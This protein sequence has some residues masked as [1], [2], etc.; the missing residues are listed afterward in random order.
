MINPWQTLS[1][2]IAYDNPWIQVTHREVINPSGG[3]G[4]YGQVHFKNVAIGI[5]PLDEEYNTWLVGQYRYTLEEY[6][7]EIPEGGCPL[8]TSTLE[9]AKRELLE[10]TG[11]QAQQWTELL[12]MHTSNSVTDEYGYAFVAKELTFGEAMPEETED[13]KLRKLPFEEAFAM[14]MQGEITDSLSIAALMKCKLWMQ[15]GKI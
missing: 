2:K 4:I 1:T 15:E 11:I 12:K 8:G 3:K 9:T 6:T 13:L 5:V 10:E 14:V 7:W